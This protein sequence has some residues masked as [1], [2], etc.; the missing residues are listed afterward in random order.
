MSI[1]S[2]GSTPKL[3]E[4]LRTVSESAGM[5]PDNEMHGFGL[6]MAGLMLVLLIPLLP[7]FAV[8]WLVSK[9]VAVVRRTVSDESDEPRRG[10]RPAA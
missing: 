2:T 8:I 1:D 7:I 3:P 9:G 10:R 6:L 4:P 5:R